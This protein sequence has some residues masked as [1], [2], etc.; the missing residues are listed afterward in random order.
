[1]PLTR[2]RYELREQQPGRLADAL[3]KTLG[4]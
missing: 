3:A 4:R 2:A 1:V